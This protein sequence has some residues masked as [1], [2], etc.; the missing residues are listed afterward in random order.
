MQGGLPTWD[1]SEGEADPAHQHHISGST[2]TCHLSRRLTGTCCLP[3]GPGTVT[4]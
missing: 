3:A 4:H 2:T 1:L